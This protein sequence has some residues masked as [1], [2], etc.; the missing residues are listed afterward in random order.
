MINNH[1]FKC[2]LRTAFFQCIYTIDSI[3][4][5]AIKAN[6]LK[7]ASLEHICNLNNLSTRV[8]IKDWLLNCICQILSKYR[9]FYI[10]NKLWA[11][12]TFNTLT[13]GFSY[14]TDGRSFESISKN[15]MN[16]NGYRSLSW[17]QL[18]ICR[19]YNFG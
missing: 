5:I 8:L 14:G 13:T 12:I 16:I 1:P 11:E 15:L 6:R 10:S 9:S 7:R 19:H 4:T 3:D 2:L 17:T 18:T